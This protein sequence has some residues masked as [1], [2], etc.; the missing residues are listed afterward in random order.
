MVTS[1]FLKRETQATLVGE[2]SRGHPN[3]CDN[4]E[5]MTLPNSGLS[6]E[7]TTKVEKHWAELGDAKWVPIDVEI[8][9]RFADYKLGKD[10]ALEY[11][12][13]Q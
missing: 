4:N 10:A 6:I 3:K 5:Y 11:A 12:I 1:I 9:P 13:G 7:Y 8:A 2:P